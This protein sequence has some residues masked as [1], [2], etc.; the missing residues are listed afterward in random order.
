ML[1]HTALDE[2]IRFACASGAACSYRYK[3][4]H[5]VGI[6]MAEVI[7]GFAM[8]FDVPDLVT[9]MAPRPVLLVSATDDA[10]SH[11]A[12]VVVSAA[13]DACAA[14]G[15][16]EQVDHQRYVGGHRLTQERFDFIVDWLVACP[17][18]EA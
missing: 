9:C 18:R 5:D 12:D 11:D 8:R 4:E 1:F 2:R 6:E 14:L 16:P 3:L 10:A 17:R 13:R 7:P 15:I